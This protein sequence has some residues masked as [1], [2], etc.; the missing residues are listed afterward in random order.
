MPFKLGSPKISV[1]ASP[2]LLFRELTRR[3]LQDVLPVQRDI[4][5]EYAK[6]GTGAADLAIQLPTGSGKTLTGLL[7]ADW[8]L[9]KNRERVI[10]LCPNNQLVHQVVEDANNKYGLSVVGLEGAKRDYAAASKSAYEQADKVAVTNY[11]SLFNT[12]SYFQDP[13]LII[14]D[15]AHASEN[16]IAKM[17]SLSV[18]G[19]NS[20]HQNLHTAL[21]NLLSQK[22]RRSDIGRLNGTAQNSRGWVEKL[23]TPHLVEIKDQLVDILDAHCENAGLFHVWGLLRDHVDA[24]HLYMSA[25]EILLRPLVPPTWTHAPF[26]QARQRIYMSATLGRGGD[27]ER[28]TGRHPIQ[29]QPAPP[30][31]DVQGVGRR[32]FVFP[33]MSLDPDAADALAIKMI[34]K[35]DR[36]LYLVPSEHRAKEVA[37]IVQKETRYKIFGAKQIEAN[38]KSFVTAKKAVAVL[39]NRYDGIDFPEDDCRL[40]LIEGF[41]KATNLQERFL[42]TRLAAN[43]L[44]HERS[45][46][47]TVQAIGRCTRSLRDRSAVVLLGEELPDN[48]G[49]PKTRKRY[50]PSLQS[51]LDFGVSQSKDS[52]EASFLDKFRIFLENKTEW[53][54]VNFYIESN[55]EAFEQFEP[56]SLNDLAKSVPHEIA[57]QTALWAGDSLKALAQAEEALACLMETDLKGYRA[58]WHYLAGSAALAACKHQPA[59]EKKARQH[60]GEAKEAAVSLSWLSDLSCVPG[61]QKEDSRDDWM[62]STQIEDVEKTFAKMGTLNPHNLAVREREILEGIASS[63]ATLFERGMQQLGAFLG[64]QTGKVEIEASPDPWWRLGDRFVIVFEAH[65]GAK[66]GGILSASKAR[67]AMSHPDWIRKHVIVSPDAEVI[68]VL[69]SPVQAAKPG[70]AHVLHHFSFWPIEDFRRWAAAALAQVRGLHSN[71]VEPGD[72]VWKVGAIE[73]FLHHRLDGPGLLKFLKGS[74]ASEN[75]PVEGVDTPKFS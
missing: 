56:T 41:P 30:G 63:D 13:G 15:D 50:H 25:D 39:A 67:Q 24:C 71:F 42:M 12:A 62:L 44:F 28:L 5:Q 6:S 40:L 47:R 34:M 33:S 27:L 35:V 7:I 10:Y 23:S 38:K 36:A 68:C 14:L 59:L 49:N 45:L 69:V 8:S 20:E 52:D 51:E 9:R 75:L 70:A 26:T 60:F 11:S 55:K 37:E 57:Y 58:L 53:E 21:V 18:H 4:L 1:P 72:M 54:D 64:F 65:S 66:E 22:V 61:E 29:R 43:A 46:T 48:L 31:T 32:Y 17:W 73:A 19:A 16:Y 2:D 74:V 3:T